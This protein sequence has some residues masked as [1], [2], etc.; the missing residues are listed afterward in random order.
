AQEHLERC[1]G[2]CLLELA[3]PLPWIF[4]QETE[5]G[6]EGGATPDF[7]RPEAGVVELLADGEHVF[8]AHACGEK[9]LVCIAQDKFGDFDLAWLADV[10]TLHVDT[11][12]QRR[13]IAVLL[14][15][16]PGGAPAQ[17]WRFR[18]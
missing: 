10:G 12:S 15:R 1:L 6:V 14:N 7:E 11:P 3:E 9:R 8:G 17:S 16:V 13:I 4:I 18:A 2:Q 5:T